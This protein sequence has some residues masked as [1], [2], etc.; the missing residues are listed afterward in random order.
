VGNTNKSILSN[1]A[2][3]IFGAMRVVL[4]SLVREIR[5][6]GSVRG[7]LAPDVSTAFSSL[8][9]KL[10][11]IQKIMGFSVS[12]KSAIQTFAIGKVN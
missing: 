6:Q 5:T 2:L 8:K 1:I 7:H 3:K 12:H 4:K 11:H 9:P 10:N